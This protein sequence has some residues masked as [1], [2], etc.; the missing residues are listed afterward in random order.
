MLKCKVSRR[1]KIILKRNKSW[2]I[3]P[4]FKT[5]YKIS[6][7]TIAQYCRKRHVDQTNRIIESR[8]KPMHTHTHMHRY[9]NF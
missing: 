7:I 1:A 3:Y 4:D 8:N 9:I 6:V 5:Y 2:R